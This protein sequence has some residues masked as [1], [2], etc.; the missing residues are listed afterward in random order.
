MSP[1]PAPSTP[2]APV[3]VRPRLP[4]WLRLK[5]PTSNTFAQTR[6][7]LQDLRLHTVCESAKCPNHWE[8]WSKGTA[9]FMI[10]GDRC[11]RACGFCAVSTAKP[12][13][14]EADEVFQRASPSVVLIVVSDGL[15]RAYGSASGV[16]V[17]PGEIVTNCH[18]VAGATQVTVMQGAGNRQARARLHYADP[19]RDLCQLTVPDKSVFAR[20]VTEIA[21]P[22]TIRVGARVYAVGAPRGLE[23]TLSEGIVSSLREHMG[24]RFIQTTAAISPGSSGGGLFDSQARLVAITSFLMK[25]AQNLNFAYPAFYIRELPGRSSAASVDRLANRF[26]APGESGNREEV[27]ERRSHDE[28]LRRQADARRLEELRRQGFAVPGADPAR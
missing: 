16:V 26:R 5:L 2:P 1:S 25:D 28:A 4:E 12:L 14:L 15:G 19:E 11:T 18:A 20:T 13:A 27:D 3:A 9:T 23:L 8:C 22:D 10:A 6:T 24:T 7:L 17:A 21:M